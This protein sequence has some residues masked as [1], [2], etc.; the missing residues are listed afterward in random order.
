MRQSTNAAR[1]R[2]VCDRLLRT[3]WES[4]PV[5]ATALGIH[6]Y[7]N[8]LGDV[9]SD[10][11]L[12]Q[13]R[14]FGNLALALEREIEPSLLEPDE[15]LDYHVAL[16]LALTHRI[17]L[18]DQLLW[19][20]DPSMYPALAIMGCYS[21]LVAN[22]L[23]MEDKAQ[24]ILGRLRDVP[25]MLECSKRN[26]C[27][28]P[29][30][31]TELAL[32]MTNTG[33]AFIEH[34]IPGVAKEASHLEGALREAAEH[35]VSALAAYGVWL[36]ECVQPYAGGD[37]AVGRKVY[38]RLLRAQHNLPHA[39]SDLENIAHRVLDETEAQLRDVAHRID[40]SATW[41]EL[42]ERLSCEHPGKDQLLNAYKAAASAA[43]E[44]VVEHDL[45]T[46]P[47]GEILEVCDTPEFERS[48]FPFAAY[49]PPAP[50]E[51][52]TKGHLWVTPVE[53]NIP[54]AEQRAQ[55]AS[56]CS[57]AIPVT[58][59]H[60]CY[61]G[62]HLQFCRAALLA[63]P[64]RKQSLSNLFV[65]GWALYCEELMNQMGFY[66]D[67]RTRLLQLRHLLW[68]SCRVL[69]DVGL[70]TGGMSVTEAVRIL[71]EKVRLSEANA[72]AEVKRY[73]LTP[74]QPMSYLIGKVLIDDL[75]ERARETM[76]SGFSL[77]EFHDWLLSFG[78]VSPTLIADCLGPDSA[79]QSLQ[80]AS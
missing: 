20:R 14:E 9:S 27:D 21:I 43:R 4:S 39:T 60:E 74:T 37:F 41:P 23:S 32:A 61:P 44:F 71:V 28:P 63:S 64:I 69:I 52:S 40:P 16:S 38:E 13:A 54:E 51:G 75:R 24:S 31:F 45:V 33:V 15:R 50:F 10:S 25:S 56:H 68:R 70:H 79:Q 65:E 6:E 17:E 3:I 62:H 67:P 5:N 80:H 57:Y 35:A 8:T 58:A 18:E 34:A 78:S 12:V 36:S 29:P 47:E 46:I 11:F 73:T 26:I 1:F 76:G 53:D 72:I 42:I 66:A 19:Q 55:L 7:D 48:I 2:R 77:R 59:L 22:S 49:Y 30:I